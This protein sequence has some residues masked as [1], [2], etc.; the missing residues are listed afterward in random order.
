MVVG[1]G[2][3]G[4]A[5]WDR[6]R[7]AGTRTV[8]LDAGPARF[9]E[10]LLTSGFVPDDDV[11]QYAAMDG[12]EWIRVLGVGGRANLWGGWCNRFSDGVLQS[13]D[14]SELAAAMST[15]YCVAEEWLNVSTAPISPMFER[16]SAKFGSRVQ[17]RRVAA[18]S[19]S[20]WNSALI[21]ARAETLT[22]T[23]A[24]R[25]RTRESAALELSVADQTGEAT[26]AASHFVLA[27][28]PPETSR[29]LLASG[30][31]HPAIGRS[32]TDHVGVGFTLIDPR[33]RTSPYEGAL[34]RSPVSYA[35]GYVVE[36]L[37]PLQINEAS[38]EFYTANGLHVSTEMSLFSITGVGEQRPRE[39]QQVALSSARLDRFG[40]GCPRLLL[41]ATE[42]D[43]AVARKMRQECLDVVQLMAMPGMEVAEIPGT[44][45]AQRVFHPSGGVVMGANDEFPADTDGRLREWRNVWIADAS[46]FP[47][48][49]DC[50]PTLTIVAH[51][52]RMAEA[53]LR[54]IG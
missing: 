54:E 7:K 1:A 16:L 17:R 11:W 5:V 19:S 20:S 3:A 39:G 6:L 34:I 12:V 31:T 15:A 37:G 14:V 29:I 25:L 35:E 22:H 38:A 43:R 45:D 27:A 26:L 49:G 42:S 4:I 32:I 53:L 33:P 51:A 47:S 13:W 2:I 41:C 28:S 44:G 18:T 50:H 21:A 9:P 8:L 10:S 48:S 36:V 24:L 52:Q 46:V 30:A 40:R 23:V